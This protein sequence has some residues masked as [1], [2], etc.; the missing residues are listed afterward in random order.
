ML[1]FPKAV[2]GKKTPDS[3]IIPQDRIE[4]TMC[5]FKALRINYPGS[6]GFRTDR[7]P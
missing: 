2:V 5:H 6:I 4:E 7:L 1:A 3:R